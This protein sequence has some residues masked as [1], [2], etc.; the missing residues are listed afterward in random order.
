[1]N[2]RES[3]NAR[4]MAA[5]PFDDLPSPLTD[6]ERKV[7]AELEA[8]LGELHTGRLADLRSVLRALAVIV[9]F[10][11]CAAGASVAA[12]ATLTPAA[13]VAVT[14]VVCVVAAVLATVLVIITR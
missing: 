2:P 6:H 8:D 7:I 14:G 10:A 9:P 13:A 11:G 4:G 1:M 12:L 3:G 5:K